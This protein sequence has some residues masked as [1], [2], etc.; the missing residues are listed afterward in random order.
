MPT[1]VQTYKQVVE[2]IKSIALS[3]LLVKEFGIGRPSDF[4]VENDTYT[5]QRYPMV[6]LEPQTSSIA[7]F[8]RTVLGFNMLVADIA[9]FNDQESNVNA[10]N[11]SFMIIQD[12]LSKVMLTSWD[13]VDINI[14]D[15]ITIVPFQEAG[16]NGIAGWTA[17]INVEV[18]SPLNLC[19]AAFA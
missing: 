16:K 18:K 4:D 12:I 11:N 13:N 1:P 6:F 7:R 2:T 14:L 9:D 5:F 3:H 15:P 8:G 10:Q 17:I 19:S